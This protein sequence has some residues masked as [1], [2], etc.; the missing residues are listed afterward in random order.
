MN[1]ELLF[2]MLRDT[3]GPDFACQTNPE[4]TLASPDRLSA[5]CAVMQ[6]RNQVVGHLCT[7]SAQDNH[8]V[9]VGISSSA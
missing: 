3:R 8:H 1:V 9:V 7:Q 4:S 6:P 5:P 2:S